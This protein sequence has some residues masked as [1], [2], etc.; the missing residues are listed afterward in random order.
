MFG[1]QYKYNKPDLKLLIMLPP[2]V[3]DYNFVSHFSNMLSRSVQVRCIKI[4]TLRR[5]MKK[6][7][8]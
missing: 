7:Y 2:C 5:V 1:I 3:K 6:V 4:E 8:N